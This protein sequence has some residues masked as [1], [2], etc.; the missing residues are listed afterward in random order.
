MEKKSYNGWKNRE[1][2]NVA[3]WLNNDVSYYNLQKEFRNS[4]KKTRSSKA[5]YQAFLDFAGLDGHKTPDGISFSNMKIDTRAIVND[6]L[7][8]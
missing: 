2:W 1:T 5:D 3:L 8:A 7:F 4:Y 6:V